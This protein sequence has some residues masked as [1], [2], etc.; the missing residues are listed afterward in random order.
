MKKISYKISFLS[1]ALGFS[2]AACNP[3]IESPAFNRGDLDLTRYVAIGNSLTAGFADGGLY[4]E[5]QINS[6]PN[7]L[8]QQFQ[9][10]GGGE[11][12]QPLFTEAQR[13][14]SGYL[15]VGGF[16]PD[17][18]PNLVLVNSNLALRSM[19]PVLFTKYVGDPQ[20][21]GVTGIKLRDIMVQGYGSTQGNPHFERLLQEGDA[22]TT[23]YFDKVRNSDAT[24]F[25]SWLGS[26]DVL[27]SAT[28]GGGSTAAGNAITPVNDFTATYGALLTELAANNR[29]GVLVTIPNVTS[30]PFFT[31]VGPRVKASLRL[32]QTANPNIPGLVALTGTGPQRTVVPVNSIRSVEGTTVQ[33]TAL[34]PLTA[35]SYAPL[36]GT[37]T[38]RFWR[39]NTTSQVQL[40]ATLLALGIDTLQ[41]FGLS[42]GNP[43][44]SPLL[45]DDT[46]L[47]NIK[48]ATDAYN[49]FII[50]EGASRNL[51][52]CDIRPLLD[53]AN[54]PGGIILEGTNAT[55]AFV[56]GNI[57]SL[58]GIHLTPRGYAIVANEIIRSINTKYNANIPTVR[59]VNY[60]GV[61]FPN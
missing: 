1:L 10:V 5:A 60:R 12:E 32:A 40:A 25:S 55:G 27:A 29:R 48:T 58:D 16:T 41:P 38:G 6:Y 56:T 17:G 44:P 45:L 42:A 35:A 33:G 15:R 39:E 54:A 49:A 3:E 19:S 31:V 53:R 8:A 7:I 61:I 51:A 37:P 11:F 22:P 43:W 23:T 21:L 24:F 13:N 50:Q 20:N 2:V 46:E 59:E 36:I 18:N 9:A 47:N 30:A 34:L 28:S 52:V 14:G 4:R 26:N 57:F